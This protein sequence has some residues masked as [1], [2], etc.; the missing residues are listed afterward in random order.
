MNRFQAWE[1]EHFLNLRVLFGDN[2]Q[3]SKQGDTWES[4]IESALAN[5]LL[6]L[7]ST[8]SAPQQAALTLKRDQLRRVC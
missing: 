8:D 4:N 7:T 6:T 2:S 5:L 1:A 3:D